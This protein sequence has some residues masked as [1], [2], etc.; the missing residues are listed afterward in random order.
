M[1]EI[2]PFKQEDWGALLSLANQAAPFASQG[3]VAWFE[4]RKSFDDSQRIRRHYIAI[5][6][7]IPVGYGCIEQHSDALEWLRIFVVCSPEN[8]PG[9][10]G[11]RLYEKLLQNA[12]ELQADHLWAQEYQADEPIGKF[13]TGH[14]FEEVRRFTRPNELPM[15]VY[16]FDLTK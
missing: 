4:N 2:R 1:I 13:F 14:G 9:E 15:V 12:K 8:L 10:V 7:E 3:N 5:E 16:Q 11:A 6:N